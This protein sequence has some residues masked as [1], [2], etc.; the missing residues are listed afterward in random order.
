MDVMKQLATIARQ[1]TRMDAQR[2]TKMQERD[3]LIRQARDEGNSWLEIQHTTGLSS[4]A[5][6]MSLERT[7]SY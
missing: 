5:I 7:A 2:A 6:K 1:L 4:R 3:Q